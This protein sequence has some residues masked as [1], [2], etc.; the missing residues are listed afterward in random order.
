VP[1][2]LIKA[3]FVVGD[4]TLNHNEKRANGLAS[5]VF[6]SEEEGWEGRRG[7]EEGQK[8]EEKD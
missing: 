4:I 8:E 6:S 2:L 5:S 1:E 3:L 7:G